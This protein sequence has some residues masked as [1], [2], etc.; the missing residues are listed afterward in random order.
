MTD[1]DDKLIA[2]YRQ[3][4]REE[5][6]RALDD[7]V[8]AASRRALARPGLAR[9]WAAP[10]SI[11][12]VLVLAFGV[13]LEMQREEPGIE[14]REPAKRE[15]AA[16]Y[17]APAQI[18]PAAP[19]VE[20]KPSSDAL[21]SKAAAP[22]ATART[23]E[24]P[25]EAKV[26]APRRPAPPLQKF[27]PAPAAPQP[28]P[29]AATPAGP[30]QPAPSRVETMQAAPVERARELNVMP[31]APAAPAMPSTTAPASAAA[32]AASPRAKAADT[33]GAPARALAPP[34]SPEGELERIAR[35]REEGRESEADK[36]L[37]EFRRAHP[38]YRIPDALWARVKPR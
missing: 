24:S 33:A 1:S 4:P 13:T 32:P 34:A 27:T 37:D 18:P 21:E 25:R 3:L 9:R 23:R 26:I 16:P 31:P 19:A 15:S 11:A 12:A 36:A 28:F 5:P 38:G 8:L 7:L 29:E 6:P 30:P 22:A 17:A 35:L 10:V 2:R 14:Y 20:T